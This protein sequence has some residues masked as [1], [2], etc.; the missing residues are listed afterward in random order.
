MNYEVRHVTR[1]EYEWLLLEHHYAKRVPSISHAFGLF[2]GDRII[3][4]VTFGV[5]ASRQV[6]TG[7]CPTAPSSVI[8]LNRLC[9]LDEAPRN[10]ESWFIARALRMLPPYIVVSYADTIQGHMGF[11]YRA[12]N[13][14]Y[15]GWT[16]MD[17]KTARYDYVVPGKHSR[18]AFRGEKPQFTEKVRRRPKVK[19]WTVT[20]DKRERNRL[21]KICSWLNICWGAYPPP[22]EHQHVVIAANDNA[23]KRVTA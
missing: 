5:P 9:V 17:R 16:D 10:T 21:T 22:V 13:F 14:N 8:E 12:A 3:G 20:G 11:V 1:P 15:A 4:V 7:A 18:D 19:Y 6:Q 23:A 2:D